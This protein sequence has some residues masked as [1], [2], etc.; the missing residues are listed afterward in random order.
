MTASTIAPQT[1]H[2]QDIDYITTDSGNAERLVRE[3]RPDF[4]YCEPLGGW[5]TWTGIRWQVDNA[6]IYEK[7]RDIGRQILREASDAQDRHVRDRLIQHA[8]YTLGESGT[9]RMIALAEKDS[10]VRVGPELFDS[11]PYLFNVENGTLNLLT[12]DLH[13]HE[14]ENLMTKLAYVSHD[15]D[16][17]APTFYRFI[18]RVLPDGA[19]RRYVRK[20]LGYSLSG[21]SERQEF[22]LN[23]GVGDNGK[24]T[25]YDTVLTLMGDYAATLPIDALMTRQQG[26]NASPEI[27]SL[28]GRRLV[29][30]SESD[31]NQRIKPGL[32]KRLTG[33]KTITARQLY[34]GLMT[35]ERQF[36]LFLHV[37]HKPEIGDDGHGM[38]RRVK[39]IPWTVKI[40][41]AEKDPALPAKLEAEKSG[42]L[43]W[44]LDGYKLYVLE[45]LE[46]P[47]PIKD[48]TD[49]Y[50]A[51]SS[52]MTL[53]IKDEC[54]TG[55]ESVFVVKDLLYEA[56]KDWCDENRVY[57]E[58]KKK[59]GNKLIE[60]GYDKDQQERVNG[61][62]VRVWRGI[63]LKAR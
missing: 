13:D 55:D 44:M 49:D 63:G 58:S 48:A 46:P 30:A 17:K 42:I 11:D 24:N 21:G 27:A 56:Y 16:A 51:E 1:T 25:L 26:G 36:K 6:A 14:R 45:G 60:R 34:K 4:R 53:F 43:N 29:V 39:L 33:D 61:S 3:H 41:R 37:N 47:T 18:R 12:G 32:I 38:W 57:S 31:E 52:K 59:F 5:L 35:F 22:Y 8:R 23:Q 10:L 40:D 62:K 2:T 28:K 20:A 19:V 9:R 50:R 15:P 7:A 54:V